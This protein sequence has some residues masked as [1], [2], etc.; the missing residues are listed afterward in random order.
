MDWRNCL[1]AGIIQGNG[2]FEELP[3]MAIDKAKEIAPLARDRKLYAKQKEML[4]GENSAINLQHGPAHMLK[5][6]KDFEV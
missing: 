6:S 1:K 4:Y 5:N 3:K 2:L